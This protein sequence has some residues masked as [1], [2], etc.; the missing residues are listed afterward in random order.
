MRVLILGATGFIGGQIARAGCE[1]GLDVHGLRRRAGAVGAIGDLPVTWHQGDLNDPT[2][3]EAAMRGCDVLFH[4][5]AYY[6]YHER[7]PLAAMHRAALEIRSVLAAAQKADVGRVI[8]TSSLTTIGQLPAGETRLADERDEYVPGSARNAYFEAK[9]VMEQEAR[10]AASMGLPVVVLI[11]TGVF[12]PGDVKPVT[13][14][15]LCDL[16][17]GR[18]PVG[19]DISFNFVDVRDVAL[20]HIRAIKKGEA[21]HRYLIGGHNLNIGQALREAAQVIGVKPPQAVIPRKTVVSLVRL[22]GAVPSLVPELA[23]GIGYWQPLNCE[24]GWKTFGLTPRPFAE[25]VRDGVG[26]FREHGYL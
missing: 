15:I 21:G 10:L 25:M 5:A 9:W 24:K 22:A 11:P 1:A 23:R 8:Y 6:P 16:A 13:G 26:W 19:I 14:Q 17:K 12:G 4:A 20:A 7:N 18:M 3:I 2:S